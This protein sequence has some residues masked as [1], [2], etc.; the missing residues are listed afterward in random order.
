MI[1]KK[2]QGQKQGINDRKERKGTET[3]NE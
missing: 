2:G 3:L 1:E